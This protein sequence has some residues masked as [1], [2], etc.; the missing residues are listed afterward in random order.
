[1]TQSTKKTLIR[2]VAL[3][4]AFV[5]VVGAVSFIGRKTNGTFEDITLETLTR[6]DLNE[7]NLYNADLLTIEKYNAGTG[8]TIDAETDG[9]LV[10][11]G[12]LGGEN[13]AD[14]KV[15]T[16]DLKK[17]TYTLSTGANGI[18]QYSVYMYLT[19]DNGTTKLA[20]DFGGVGTD[21]V[22]EIAT[23][24]SYDIYIHVEADK[25]FKDKHFYPTIVEGEEKG[26]FYA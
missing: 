3:I 13:A 16:I 8:I 15:G 7:D 2:G 9:V 1:M 19:A 20:F 25:E 26:D 24:D 6:K 21:G 17:G 10:L 5:A 12:K 14:I 4:V 22:Y 23:A 18:G 11:D